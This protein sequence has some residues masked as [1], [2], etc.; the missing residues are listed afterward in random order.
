MLEFEGIRIIT[1][2]VKDSIDVVESMTP[3]KF[4]RVNDFIKMIESKILVE[5]MLN[6]NLK[7]FLFG[8]FQIGFIKQGLISKALCMA[9]GTPHETQPYL[10]YQ[11]KIQI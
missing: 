8:N 7:E 4:S 10:F 2:G 5:K 6:Q 9:L 11:T 3:L 1:L